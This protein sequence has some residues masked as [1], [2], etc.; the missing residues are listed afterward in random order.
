VS[1]PRAPFARPRNHCD[2][3]MPAEKTA[4][5]K[6]AGLRVANPPAANRAGAARTSDTKAAE[7]LESFKPRYEI[8]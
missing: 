3:V 7:I 2:V 6:P 4:Q 1:F 5:E 8:L